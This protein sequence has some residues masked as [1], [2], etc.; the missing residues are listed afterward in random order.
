M[1]CAAG[2]ANKD[3]YAS[4]VRS[5]LQKAADTGMVSL[6]MPLIGS[7]NAGWP[8]KEAAEVLVE[9]LKGFF[10]CRSAVSPL[11]V[12]LQAAGKQR[13]PVVHD[14]LVNY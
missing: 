11:Q 4:T 6:A 3:A 12:V 7:E 5:V 9:E 14:V 1:C 10:D 13:L 8:V 2:V